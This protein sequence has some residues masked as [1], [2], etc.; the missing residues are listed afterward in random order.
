MPK[1]VNVSFETLSRKNSDYA[2]VQDTERMH[3][4]RLNSMFWEEKCLAQEKPA[5][6]PLSS[7]LANDSLNENEM[8]KRYPTFQVSKEAMAFVALREHDPL[9]LF[10]KVT[11]RSKRPNSLHLGRTALSHRRW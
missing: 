9:S 7:G 8:R 3:G 1:L 10:L 5:E 6:L 11:N 2:L 4:K